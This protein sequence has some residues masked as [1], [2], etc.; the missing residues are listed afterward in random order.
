MLNPVVLSRFL[1]ASVLL[2]AAGA[3]GALL[4]IR[5]RDISTSVVNGFVICGAVVTLVLSIAGLAG[6]TF[7][8]AIPQVLPL[9]G[10]LALGLDRLSAFFLLVI[11][12]GVIPCALYAAGYTRHYAHGLKPMGFALNIFVPA[13]MLVVL[14]RNVVTFLIFWE[15]MSLSSYFLV[16][17]ESD[18]DETRSAGWLYMIMTHAGLAC[19]LIGFLSMAQAAGTGTMS[20]WA[21][22]AVTMN[23]GMRNAIFLV[24][25]A[26]FLSKAGAIPFHIWLPRAH[27]AAPSHVSALMSGVMIKLG[28]Y[29]LIR[30]GFGWLGTSPAWWGVVILMVGVISA[31]LGILYALVEHDIKRLL[32]YSSVENIGIIIIGVGAAML[33]RISNLPAL[34]G[35]ALVAALYHTLNHAAFKSLLFAGAGSVLQATGTRNMEEMGGLIRKMPRTA[36]LFL[37]G[38][39]AISALPPLNGFVSEWLTFQSLLLSFQIHDQSINL[40]FAIAVAALALTGGLAAAC[41]VKAFGITFLALPRSG[42]VENASDPHW[43]MTAAMAILAAL[44]LLLGIAPFLFVPSLK[45]LALEL[46][47]A[48]PDIAIN[49]ARITTNGAFAGLSPLWVF[50][51]LGA[52]LAALPLALALAGR[53]KGGRIFETWGC[54]RAVQTA[55]F[56]YTATAFAYPF[57]RVFAVLYRPVEETQVEA[58]PESRLFVKTITYRHEQSS[59]IED[60]VYA[61]L[62]SA[63]RRV[64]VRARALQS[65]NVHSYLLYMLVVLLVLLLFAK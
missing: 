54:G 51:G 53:N 21:R 18:H 65:G 29:G 3:I 37:A 56:E 34:S 61:P 59:V 30:I 11:A 8:I 36:A 33:F 63:V 28:V 49:W 55:K 48:E 22:T 39:V 19:L 6:G 17:T 64:A 12:A 25:A 27:P 35:L 31:L 16:M 2:F 23:A 1:L 9:A 38:T 50:L 14:A 15:L 57:K 7:D 5:R 60:F 4:P 58:H 45:G 52:L 24:L 44:C 10:G 62:G 26:G 43:T 20:E 13:M 46:F 40:V 42:R 32:A 47:G 41:F